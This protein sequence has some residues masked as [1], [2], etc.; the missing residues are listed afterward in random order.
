MIFL[1]LVLVNVVVCVLCMYIDRY[2]LDNFCR[3]HPCVDTI[4]KV[5]LG[6]TFLSVAYILL[7]TLISIEVLAL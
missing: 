2:V 1:E 7:E 5:W 4:F 3:Q 6:A